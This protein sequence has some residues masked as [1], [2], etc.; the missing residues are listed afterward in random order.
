MKKSLWAGLGVLAGCLLPGCMTGYGHWPKLDEQE[1]RWV[2]VVGSFGAAHDL[3]ERPCMLTDEEIDSG[4]ID[5]FATAPPF[6]AR[7]TVQD[8]LFGKLPPKTIDVSASTSRGRFRLPRGSARP[9]IVL[10]VTDGKRHIA[11]EWTDVARLRSGGWAIP[12]IDAEDSVP[13]LPCVAAPLVQPLDF[14]WPRPR[15][16]VD[17]RYVEMHH[18]ITFADVRRVLQKQS[19]N[20]EWWEPTD[21]A[22]C[23]AQPD[24]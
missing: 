2:V 19:E 20:A 13:V 4:V 6:Q 12:V 24:S 3:D 17:E 11:R 5:C 10:L 21:S 9:Q 7:L 14:A 8:V 22:A 16:F 18:G 23:L 15:R 1:Q